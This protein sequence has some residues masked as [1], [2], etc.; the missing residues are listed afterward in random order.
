MVLAL[1]EPS[2]MDLSGATEPSEWRHS[3]GSW[4]LFC[5]LHVESKIAPKSQMVL[6][7]PE[8]SEWRKIA[9]KRHVLREQN[10]TQETCREQNSTQEPV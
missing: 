10:S 4:V 5:S 9:P 2:E 3:D 6:A 7:M 1:P 8:P